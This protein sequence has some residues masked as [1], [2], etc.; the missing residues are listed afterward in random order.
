VE[1]FDVY[2]TCGQ[3]C[4]D[5]PVKSKSCKHIVANRTRPSPDCVDCN[6]NIS[7]NKSCGYQTLPPLRS[8]PPQN[9]VSST[10]PTRRVQICKGRVRRQAILEAGERE[11]EARAGAC[12]FSHG[13]KAG[14]DWFLIDEG[15]P[16]VLWTLFRLFHFVAAR[17]NSEKATPI[18]SDLPAS[19]SF[20]RGGP[21]P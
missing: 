18:L 12:F 2:Q 20:L 16:G 7:Q 21:R 14:V 3:T 19:R 4:C 17:C 6:T 5:V 9:P 10:A 1:C 15:Y 13:R 11:L 8:A